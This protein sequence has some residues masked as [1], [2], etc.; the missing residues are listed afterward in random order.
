MATKVWLANPE[1]SVE[2]CVEGVGAAIQSSFQV[3]LTF[4]TAT[5]AI[6]DNGTTRQMQKSEI[7][8]ALLNIVQNLEKDPN[9]DFG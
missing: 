4:N 1:T 9:S 8:K 6:N 7:V 3:S 5:N 2:N